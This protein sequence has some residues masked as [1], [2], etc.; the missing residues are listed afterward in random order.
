MND[1]TTAYSTRALVLR[2][3]A[4]VGVVL[5]SVALKD[6]VL[7]GESGPSGTAGSRVIDYSVDSDLLDAELPVTV[8]IPPGAR[9]GRRS[10]LVF[11]HG[12]GDDE[13]TYLE[14]EMFD[15]LARQGGRAPVVAFPRGGPDSYWHDRAGGAWRS[16][17]LEE[18]IP[19]LVARFGIEPE[20]IAIGGISMGGFG[21]FDL[22]RRGAFRLR[23]GAETEFCAVGGHSPAI[24][25]EA[26]QTAP[27][28]FDDDRD[29][30]DHDVIELVAP[31][32]SPLA[33]TSYWLDVGEGDPFA[34]AVRALGDG[35]EA[36]GAEGRLRVGEGG[37][38]SD[39]WRSNWRRY[40]HFYAR[41]LKKCQREATERE[42][43]ADERA[44][45]ADQGSID[46]G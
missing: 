28:A 21:A 30:A 7:D 10:L 20:R 44:A 16:Y 34:E 6:S 35:L 26:S 17:V 11:L 14:A 43:R 5:V 32:A 37:H 39:Y 9:D 3:L 4:A 27:G 41:A 46:A 24:W 25:E 42:Q 8:V 31:P 18:L 45:G 36:G 22:A 23:S 2:V 1:A 38:D 15:A 29:F 12:R 33:G 13:Q 19:Q 40:M